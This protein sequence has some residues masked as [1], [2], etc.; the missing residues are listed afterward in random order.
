MA[1]A[2]TWASLKYPHSLETKSIHFPRNFQ[3]LHGG[4]GRAREAEPPE[5]DILLWAV[6]LISG[7]YKGA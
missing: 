6:L 5:I 1:R 4:L 3:E 2:R 7:G